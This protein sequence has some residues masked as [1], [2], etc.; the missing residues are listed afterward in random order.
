M[1]PSTSLSQT[2]GKARSLEHLTLH[3][4]I[5]DTHVLLPSLAEGQGID[6]SEEARKEHSLMLRAVDGVVGPF[7]QP[8]ILR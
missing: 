1:F 5:R 7:L 6:L 2:I 8:L 3:D 4:R